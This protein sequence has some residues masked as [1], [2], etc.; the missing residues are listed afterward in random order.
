[1]NVDQMMARICVLFPSFPPATDPQHQAWKVEFYKVLQPF[2]PEIVAK[3]WD[4][5]MAGR[6]YKSAPMPAEIAEA[7][8]D[9]VKL[10]SNSSSGE[11]DPGDSKPNIDRSLGGYMTARA[12]ELRARWLADNPALVQEAKAGDWYDSLMRSVVDGSQV[13]A[14]LEWHR[15]RNP[16]ARVA[17]HHMVNLSW[18]EVKGTH[19]FIPLEDIERWRKRRPTARAARPEDKANQA[20]AASLRRAA[21]TVAQMTDLPLPPMPPD[22]TPPAM[23]ED[24][25]RQDVGMPA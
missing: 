14:S 24:D 18:S 1:M 9:F 21:D 10:S 2:P 15:K 25:Y 11:W 17:K 6:K 3:G 22:D 5:M 23:S 13:L 16:N 7:C 8:R 20:F 19:I 12:P 4:K